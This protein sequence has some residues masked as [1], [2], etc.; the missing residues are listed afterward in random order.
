[1]KTLLLK[2]LSSAILLTACLQAQWITGFYESTNGVESVAN[3]PW[4]KYT[5]IVHFAAAPGL[6]GSGNG[7]GSVILH[8]LN[9]SEISQMIAA[10]PAGKR[11][12]FAYRTMG[13]TETLSPRAR[14]RE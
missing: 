1:M 7:N 3:I 11:S 6:D 4:N 8:W 13:V 10:R 12:W 9:Q 2:I 5:H 14:L